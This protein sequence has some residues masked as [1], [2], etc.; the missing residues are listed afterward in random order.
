[1]IKRVDHTAIAVKNLEEAVELY[2]KLF[3]VKASHI[4]TIPDQGVRAALIPIGDTEIELLEPIDPQS[5]VAK[6]LERRGEGVHHISLE[7]DDVDR[8]VGIDVRGAR[9]TRVA[10]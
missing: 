7:V 10:A 4:E 5:G 8:T 3:G 2:S 1:M 6:F 9:R